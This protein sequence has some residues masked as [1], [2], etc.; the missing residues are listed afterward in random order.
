[1]EDRRILR[2]HEVLAKCRISRPTADRW[3]RRKKFPKSFALTDADRGP[4]GFWEDEI[5]EYLAK[6]PVRVLRPM[7]DET[8]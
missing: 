3:R 1:M 8:P 7:P 5:D 2:M 6:R 4:I